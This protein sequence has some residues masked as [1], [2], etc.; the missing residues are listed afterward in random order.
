M[1]EK[2]LQLI[3]FLHKIQD[4]GKYILGLKIMKPYSWHTWQHNEAIAFEVECS[5]KTPR[6]Y[7]EYGKI[8]Y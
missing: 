8:Y 1:N 6:F 2:Q 4:S 5:N 7:Y 3:T